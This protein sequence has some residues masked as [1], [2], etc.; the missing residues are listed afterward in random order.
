MVIDPT[1]SSVLYAG[2]GESFGT[3][4]S[5]TKGELNISDKQRGD[6]VFKSTDGGITW[7][8]LP[9]TIPRIR[10]YALLP[11]LRARGHT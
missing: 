11:D 4:L 5:A 1:N 9:Q 2:T 8:Q 10:P 7:N 3:D 6:G